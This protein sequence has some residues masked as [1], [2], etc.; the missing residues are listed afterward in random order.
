[1]LGDVEIAHAEREVHRINIFK[2]VGEKGNVGQREDQRQAGQRA[3]RRHDTG[4]RR[5]ASFKLPSR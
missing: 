5:S 4:R 3:P 1:M 2:R